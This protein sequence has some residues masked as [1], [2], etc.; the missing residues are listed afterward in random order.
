MR[1]V[2]GLAMAALLLLSGGNAFSREKSEREKNT[3]RIMSYNIRNG[4]GLD[5]VTDFRRTADAIGRAC[6]D[7]VAV[8]ELDSVT[9]RSG[10]KDVLREIAGLVLMHPVYAPAID[11]DGGK[12]GIGM[13]SKEKPLGCRY[14]PLPGREE[15]RAL[16]VVEFEKYIYACTH[17]SLT[18][19]D[20]LLSLPVIRQVAASAG[21]PFFLGG[22]MN[23]HPDS[24]FIRRLEEDFVILTDKKKPTFPA[25]VPDETIDYIAAYAR[26]TVAFTR[27]SARVCDEPAASDHRPVVADILFKQPAGKIFL[28]EPYLQNPVGN[29]ITV[30]WQTTVPTYSWVEYGTDKE[31]LQKARTIVDGQVICN[32]LQNKIRLSDLEP[33][34]TYYYRICSQEIMLY[35][36]YK[37]VFGET[38]MSDFYTFTLPTADNKDFTAIIF[39]DLHKHSETLQ[40]LYRQVKDLKYDFVVFN[41]DCIDDPADHD[42]ATR[43]LS[44]LNETV[45][46]NRVPVFYIRGNHEI[47]NAYSIGLRSLFDYVGDKTYGAFNWGDTRFVMLDCGEDKPDTHWVYYG[48]NDFSD[49]RKAQI[50]FLKEELSSNAFKKASKRVLIHHIPI[51][52]K[53]EEYDSYNPCRD[54]WGAILEKAPFAVSLNAH[55]HRFACYP[56]GTVG[57]P[58]PVVVGGGYRMDGATVMV[59]QKKGKDMT[60]RVLNTKGETL[61]M[62]N[63]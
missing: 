43:F 34:K 32:G 27:L 53:G 57:N 19:E 11:Y 13:L 48:L 28:T 25:D 18:E 10:G 46:A 60:L 40:A 5:N 16:L 14:L 36:A 17:L 24:D 37:K 45:G 20:R 39:N 30:M 47:R 59:L 21:K 9:G 12:Y 29:G 35:Q 8:Q 61:Q 7:V 58:Y 49:L 52:G 23:A 26:D 31:H 33:G 54:E 50:G 3:L 38:A 2:L 41:G 55:T 63:L 1:R 44:E 15:A 56:K 62:L 51:Y 42:E 4:K 22:D 6:P